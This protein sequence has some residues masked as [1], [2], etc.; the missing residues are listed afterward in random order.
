[1]R[2]PSG[3]TAGG[4]AAPRKSNVVFSGGRMSVRTAG[5]FLALW[6]FRQRATANAM[7]MTPRIAAMLHTSKL[8]ARLGV[9][10]EGASETHRNSV[11]T[12]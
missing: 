2:F 12:S 10:V 11:A 5:S 3:D 7:E 6:V 1:M 9:V 8:R 4:A